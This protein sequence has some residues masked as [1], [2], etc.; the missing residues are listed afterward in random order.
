MRSM[1]PQNGRS[2]I[3]GFQT[4][5]GA[6]H[7][8]CFQTKY[9]TQRLDSG[10]RRADFCAGTRAEIRIDISENDRSRI[11]GSQTAQGA[12]HECCFQT[13]YRTQRLDSGWLGI[14][15]KAFRVGVDGTKSNAAICLIILNAVKNYG[16]VLF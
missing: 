7:E 11:L 9:R 2:S 5:Q 6:I 15:T 13:K 3:L 4:A 16:I 12:I 10:W 14:A 1:Q 8:C